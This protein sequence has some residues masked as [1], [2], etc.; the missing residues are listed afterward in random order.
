MNPWYSTSVILQWLW[1][2]VYLMWSETRKSLIWWACLF[3]PCVAMWFYVSPFLGLI[4]C[5]APLGNNTSSVAHT[6][7]IN[8]LL[9]APGCLIDTEWDWFCWI[10]DESLWVSPSCHDLWNI[11]IYR[12][13]RLTSLIYP[14]YKRGVPQVNMNLLYY[15]YI[16]EKHGFFFFLLQLW[17]IWGHPPNI[18]N[19]VIFFPCVC[20]PVIALS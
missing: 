7:K 1:V 14:E 6:S 13:G 8:G 3:F 19:D 15:C 18:T 16:S 10:R 11:I 12:V 17:Y 5:D 4:M 20:W 9:P 2:L